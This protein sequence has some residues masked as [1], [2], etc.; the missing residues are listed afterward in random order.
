VCCYKQNLGGIAKYASAET[1]IWYVNM[2]NSVHCNGETYIQIFEKIFIL[3]PSGY[4]FIATIP[5]LNVNHS[6]YF[7]GKL[8]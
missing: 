1:C 8:F 2:Y 7:Y 4:K 6:V 3:E 5:D